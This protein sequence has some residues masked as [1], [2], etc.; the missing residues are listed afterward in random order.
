MKSNFINNSSTIETHRVSLI[1]TDQ[2]NISC[3][4]C[5]F[6]SSPQKNVLMKLD[7]AFDYINQAHE[8]PTVRLISI[9]GG[10]PFLF[11][12]LIKKIVSFSANRGLFT[13]CV[14]NSFWAINE[15][16]AINVLKDLQTIGLD[17]IDI[18]IDDFHQSQ[19]PFERVRNCFNA[20]KKVGLKIFI[21]CTVTR[22]SKIRISNLV[23]LLG[24]DSIQILDGKNFPKILPKILAVESGFLPVGRGSS[25]PEKELI[26][27]NGPLYGPCKFILNDI[28]ITP[29]GVVLPCC[30]AAGLINGMQIGNAHQKRL[31]TIIREASEQ[32]IIKILIEKGPKAIQEIV[33]AKCRKNYVNKCHL[34][35]EILKELSFNKWNLGKPKPNTH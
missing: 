7:N 31:G 27:G 21:M 34:C 33:G 10:E 5:W 32:N 26:S 35:Y 16:F 11:P 23:K 30:S 9:T 14:T 19:I 17:V 22:S 29:S 4:H 12:E 15:L 20:A 8:I 2:C 3:R 1:L 28:A 25:I 18:S 6:E 13:E 24:D